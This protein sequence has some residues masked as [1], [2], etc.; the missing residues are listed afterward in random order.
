MHQ[1]G[2]ADAADAEA[3]YPRAIASAQ[4]EQTKTLELR[5]AVP[6]PAAGP[7]RSGPIREWPRIK[8]C[9]TGSPKGLTRPIW[10]MPVRCSTVAASMSQPDSPTPGH[11]S[12]I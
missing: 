6:L 1:H 7:G 9:M 2:T 4:D 3:L 8:R 11:S 10:R 12:P 5:A